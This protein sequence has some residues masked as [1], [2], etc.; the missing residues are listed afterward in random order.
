MDYVHTPAS[1][2][3]VLP[4]RTLAPRRSTVIIHPPVPRKVARPCLGKEKEGHSPP[5]PALLACSDGLLT[6][7]RNTLGQVGL[8]VCVCVPRSPIGVCGARFLGHSVCWPRRLPQVFPAEYLGFVLASWC[9]GSSGSVE[10][11]CPK[12]SRVSWVV[13]GLGRR[14]CAKAYL[15]RC[16]AGGPL[17]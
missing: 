7:L 2:P 1:S 9:S 11:I 17:T 12:L 8:C 4:G 5:P 16:N 13:V 15:G 6:L 10:L 14:E 3:P